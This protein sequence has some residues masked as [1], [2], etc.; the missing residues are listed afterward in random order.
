MLKPHKATQL[1]ERLVAARVRKVSLQGIFT[2]IEEEN[3][4]EAA[5]LCLERFEAR[6]QFWLYA[7]RVGAEL[8]LRLGR[9]IEAQTLVQGSRRCQNAALGQAGVS[10]ARS[11][12]AGQINQAI[13][14]DSRKI[15]RRRRELRRC[16]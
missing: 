16:L 6:G 1:G 9:C 10:H 5:R 7:A 11:L 2:A 15:D 4:E 12:E 3:F 14:V 8:L 13:H